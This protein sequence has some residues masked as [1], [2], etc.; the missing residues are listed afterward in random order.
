MLI[1]QDNQQGL[2]AT[3]AA[4][5]KKS[6]RR[7]K[8]KAT[9]AEAVSQIDIAHETASAAGESCLIASPEAGT[10][11]RSA[12]GGRLGSS[13]GGAGIEEP[14]EVCSTGDS[15]VGCR[16]RPPRLQSCVF[17]VVFQ[18]EVFSRAK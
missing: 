16:F 1:G 2:P 15:R 5:A 13:G 12:E 11:S 14:L 3:V 7:K 18:L 17:W 10:S 9:S 8:K 4:S 6:S